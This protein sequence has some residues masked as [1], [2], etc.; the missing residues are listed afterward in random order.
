MERFEIVIAGGGLAGLSLACRLACSAARPATMLIVDQ[1]PPGSVQRSWSYWADQPGVFDPVVEHRWSQLLI[2]SRSDSTLI[3]LGSYHYEMVRSLDL[4]RFARQTL[5]AQPGIAFRQGLVEQ[6]LD[7]PGGACVVVDGQPV[8]AD[9]VFDSSRRPGSTPRPRRRQRLSMHFR[10]WTVET[11]A[12]AFRPQAVTFLDFRTP[13]RHEARFFYVLP[14]TSCRA[15][16]QFVLFAPASPDAE[17][18]A[19]TLKAYLGR[20]L[21]IDDYSVVA[22]EVGSLPL[23]SAHPAR[24]RGPHVLTIGGK[25]GLVKPTTGFGFRRIQQD[26]AAIVSSLE[27][28]QA[29]WDIPP[30]SDRHRLYDALL[31]DILARRG[32]EV[33]TIFGELFA[34]N[35]IERV[36]RFLDEASTPMEDLALIGTL[37]A[38][39]FIQAA[40]RSLLFR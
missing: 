23:T 21:G 37:P 25:A 11:R 29:P 40:S 12:E 39:P 27:R 33:E 4:E 16:V 31:L 36:L 32:G 35:P 19:A 24:R 5:S 1:N 17:E 28:T 34:G 15:M 20:S 18:A 30:I 7:G 38:G 10:G 3:D 22:E 26:S 8:E 13:Q 6:I 14:F 2:N 9:W